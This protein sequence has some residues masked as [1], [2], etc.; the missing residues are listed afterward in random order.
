MKKNK[1]TFSH[2]NSVKD[3]I[4]L[5]ITG[6]HISNKF[7]EIKSSIKFLGEM[8]DGH[9]TWNDHK[10][11][12]RAKYIGLLKRVR[13]FLDKEPCRTILSHTSISM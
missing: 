5:K 2:K 3:K 10:Y 4:P 12:I 8:L 1:Y 7:I 11:T 13:Q 9:I 6:L